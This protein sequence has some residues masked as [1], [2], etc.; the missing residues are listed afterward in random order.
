MRKGKATKTARNPWYSTTE[1]AS[2]PHE[3]IR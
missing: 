1:R 3:S 2:A